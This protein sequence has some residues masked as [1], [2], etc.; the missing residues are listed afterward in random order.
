MDV[1]FQKLKQCSDTIKN[2]IIV[3]IEHVRNWNGWGI[4]NLDQICWT[5]TICENNHG[6]KNP[7]EGKMITKNWWC[8]PNIE[9][10]IKNEVQGPM[11]V[12]VCLTPKHTLTNEGECKGWNPM[13]LKC[14]P[15]LGVALVWE[16]PMFRALVGRA[17]KHQIGPLGDH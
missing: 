8:N 15:T 5:Q 11:R 2:A 3:F 9:F 10:A 17:N 12:R 7:V 4:P 16:L 13:I 6:P 1:F 14:L